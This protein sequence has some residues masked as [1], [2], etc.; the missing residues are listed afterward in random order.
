MRRQYVQVQLATPGSCAALPT[1][2][3]LIEEG[4][5]VFEVTEYDPEWGFVASVRRLVYA[6]RT[7]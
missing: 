4:D 7:F 1:S 3:G 5:I 2:I 6:R